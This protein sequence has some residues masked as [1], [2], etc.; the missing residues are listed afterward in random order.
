MRHFL[1]A[2]AAVSLPVAAFAVNPG[3][4]SGEIPVARLPIVVNLHADGSAT[5]D[6]PKQGAM[7]IQCRVTDNEEDV[8]NLEIPSLGLRIDSHLTSNGELEGTFTQG[9]FTT[10]LTLKPCAPAEPQ[11]PPVAAD[12]PTQE[13]TFPN[14]EIKLAGTLTLPEGAETAV[15]FV[16]GSGPQNRDEEVLGHRPFAVIADFL[17]RNDV[18]SLRYDDRGVGESS[19]DFASATTADFTSDARA[20]I[21]ALRATG[22]Y[23]RIGVIGHSEGGRIAWSLAPRADFIVALAPPA[24]RGDKVLLSQNRDLLVDAGVDPEAYCAALE[25]VF[26]GQEPPADAPMLANLNEVANQIA[27]SPWLAYFLTDD[28]ASDIEAVKI[29]ALAIFGEKDRQ[30]APAENIRRL[31]ELNPAVKVAL[32]PGLNHLLQVCET[33]NPGEYATILTDVDDS[34]LDAILK[35]IEQ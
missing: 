2:V 10:P 35:F 7:G 33:G 14:G 3:S 15:V 26:S 31:N 6:S 5:L 8:L 29:P 32:L 4:W 16:T 17:A 22:K 24:L 28:P 21:D 12:Y 23:K 19:G 34:A 11:S 18:A 27:K 20:A 9:A 30:V 1:S 13:F 25:L